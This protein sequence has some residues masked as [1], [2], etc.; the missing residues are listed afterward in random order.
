MK[1]VCLI[2]LV[3]MTALLQQPFAQDVV[4]RLKKQVDL[5]QKD[6]QMK[7]A[8]VGL[9][10][11]DEKGKE[12]YSLNARTGLAAAS[13]QKIFTSIAA[14]EILGPEFTYTTTLGIEGKVNGNTLDGNLVITPSGDPTLGSDRWNFT[15]EKSILNRWT[16]VIKN[17]GITKINGE[18]RIITHSFSKLR[19]PTG[20]IW[21]DVSNYYGA[22][23]GALNWKENQFDLLFNTGTAV[24]DPVKLSAIKP[25]YLD[26]IDI[27]SSELLTASKGSGDNAFAFLVPSSNNSLMVK[28]TLPAGEKNFSISVAH[29]DIAAYLSASLKNHHVL[30]PSG[31]AEADNVSGDYEVMDVYNS[32]DLDSINFWFIRKSI[33]LYGEA[34]LKTIGAKKYRLHSTENGVKALQDFWKE[35]S[36]EPAALNILDGSGLSP[37]NRLTPESLVLALKYATGKFFYK[38]FYNALPVINGMRMKSG[39]IGGARA[40]AGYHR[41]AEGKTY[42]FAI[43]VNNYHGS[44]SAVVRKMFGILDQ[45]K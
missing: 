36:I 6:P 3:L 23:H 1:K 7:Y 21:E 45:L 5:L 31:Y 11:T 8:M 9:Y 17:R 4:S 38:S 40:Y 42:N 2:A 41:S 27:N 20:W 34:L 32:P 15:N 44:S 19:F 12:I 16:N 37:Q 28:G 10:I 18:T 33:N 43:I 29:P 25:A 22:S 14:F 26:N 24:D 30:Y 13:T 39:S 35:R